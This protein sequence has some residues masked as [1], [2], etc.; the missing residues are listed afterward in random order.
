MTSSFHLSSHWLLKNLLKRLWQGLDKPPDFITDSAVNS[1][2]LLPIRQVFRQS[3]WIFKANVDN[4]GFAREHGA[5]LISMPAN[6]D[7]GIEDLTGQFRQSLGM[8]FRDV[9]TRFGHDLYC[10]RVHPVPLNT[11]GVSFKD[12]SEKMTRPAF[13]H[14]ASA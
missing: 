10:M 11:R 6:G 9:H 13:G 7:H 1:Q 8:L 14:L 5:V 3:R 12:V 4:L 2:L